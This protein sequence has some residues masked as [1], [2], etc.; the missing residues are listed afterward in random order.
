MTKIHDEAAVVVGVPVD[1]H[2]SDGTVEFALRA[3]ERLALGIEAVH[4]VPVLVGWPTGTS[5]IGVAVEQLRV[6]GQRTLDAAVTMLRDRAAGRCAVSGQLLSGKPTQ[7]LVDR[8]RTAALVVLEAT[9]PSTVERVLSGSVCASVAAFAH[10]PV[11]AVPRG[12]E[13]ARHHP[14]PVTVGVEYADRAEA[15]VWTAIGLASAEDLPVRIVRAAYLPQAFQE[16]LRREVRSE[17]WLAA[18]RVELERDCPLPEDTRR[19]VPCTY[20][21]RWGDPADVLVELSGRSSLLVVA[22]RDPRL[23]IGSHLGPVVRHVLRYATCPVMVV[24]PTLH[25]PLAPASVSS[26]G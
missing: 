1:G 3:A 4:V 18:A 16:I 14:L 26:A 21:V 20:E 7:A 5:E 8:S 22:R 13:P 25:E 11:V 24:E 9:H 6:E 19:G 2:L 15:E 17:E 23:P 12:W 10:A